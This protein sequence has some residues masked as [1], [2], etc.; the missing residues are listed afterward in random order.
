[1]RCLNAALAHLD[2]IPAESRHQAIA[3]A[4]ALEFYIPLCDSEAGRLATRSSA[5]Q[6][7]PYKALSTEGYPRVQHTRV[8]VQRGESPNPVFRLLVHGTRPYFIT[9]QPQVL[10]VAQANQ[11]D[12]TPH[13][14][15]QPRHSSF[16]ASALMS[17]A[18]PLSLVPSPPYY[19]F[20]VSRFLSRPVLF[21][22]KPSR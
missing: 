21:V 1:M 13:A 3:S 16:V 9:L 11:E 15:N 20:P 8:E 7:V 6:L 4:P 17:G 12:R 5:A 19:P 22:S 2:L 10:P 14:Q 18:Q